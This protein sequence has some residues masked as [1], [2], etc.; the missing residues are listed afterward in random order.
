MSE[1]GNM[2]EEK[3]FKTIPEDHMSRRPFDEYRYILDL[4]ILLEIAVGSSR[5]L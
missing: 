4:K 2:Q 1:P 5:Y 3:S